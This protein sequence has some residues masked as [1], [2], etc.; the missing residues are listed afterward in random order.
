[1]VTFTLI[2]YLLTSNIMKKYIVNIVIAIVSMVSMSSCGTLGGVMGSGTLAGIA[3]DVLVSQ[4]G[5]NNTVVS[6]MKDNATGK[7]YDKAHNLTITTTAKTATEG[8]YSVTYSG[9]QTYLYLAPITECLQTMPSGTSIIEYSP[10][11]HSMTEKLAWKV[12]TTRGTYT[13]INTDSSKYWLK[14]S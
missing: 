11:Y 3:G 13:V 6:R 1:M 10:C 8:V 5:L 12:K 9:G 14:N 2:L 7:W 4:L